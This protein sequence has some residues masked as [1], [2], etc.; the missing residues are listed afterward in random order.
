MITDPGFYPDLDEAAYHAD[1]VAPISC[2]ASLLHTLYSRSPLHARMAHPKLNPAREHR[3]DTPEQAFGRAAHALLFQSAE[4]QEIDA[5]DWKTKAARE[6]R[7]AVEAEGK[8]AVLADDFVLL[9]NM[10]HTLRTGLKGHELGEV[11]DEGQAETTIVWKDDGCLLRGRLD[12]WRPKWNL[13]V[14]Y[15][16]TSRAAD[17]DTWSRNLFSLGSHFQGV[18]YPDGVQQLTGIRP[19]FCYVVQETEPPYAFTVLDLDEAAREFTT[20]QVSQAFHA[21]RECLASNKW[22]GYPTNLCHVGAPVW[23]VKREETRAL[24]HAAARELVVD[25]A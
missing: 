25:A 22:H 17:P 18:L 23:A 6:Q 21:W 24:A 5:A 7:D 19:R 3:K 1:P 13:I 11:F 2:S 14:D 9:K 8:I 4:L 12:W 16:T 20:S 15:K 10:V